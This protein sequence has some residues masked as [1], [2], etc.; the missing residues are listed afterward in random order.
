[1]SK[2]YFWRDGEVL[3]LPCQPYVG[4]IKELGYV[5]LPCVDMYTTVDCQRYGSFLHGNSW[6]PIPYSEFPKEFLTA[7]LL[8]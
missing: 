5:G 7:L 3:V 6:V 8:I 1:M 4:L 2:A